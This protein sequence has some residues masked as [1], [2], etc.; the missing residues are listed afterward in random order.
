MA[1]VK[2]HRRPRIPD[3]PQR[4]KLER[5]RGIREVV[6]G[7]QDGILT[8]LGI[9]TGVG[10]ASTDR[11]TILITGLLSML[12]GAMSMGVGEYLGGKSER[13]VVQ[14]AVQ[15]ERQELAD[16]PD[17]EFA[18]QLGYYRLKGFTEE[19]ALMMVRRLKKN[20]D[21]W[22][23]EMVRDEFGIDLREAE[24]G[25]LRS[26]FGMA[27]SFAAGAVVPVLAY[28]TPLSLGAAMWVSLVLAAS[29][30][31]AIGAYAGTISGRSPVGK[32]FEVVAFGTAVFVI[33]WAAGHYV[34]PLFGHGSIS[35]GG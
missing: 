32:G 4:Q 13:E 12:V 16:M 17:A 3:T 11:P 25:G 28:L 22:L 34:P 9:V 15:R 7:M 23:H 19:E 8:T 10:G 14:S 5:Q 27:G 24:G 29:A 2:P 26:S 1:T 21:I 18:E 6:F 30:L 20:P 35:V 33:S 31:F